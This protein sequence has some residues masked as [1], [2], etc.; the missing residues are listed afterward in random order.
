MQNAINQDSAFIFTRNSLTVLG[1]YPTGGG[2]PRDWKNNRTVL[3]GEIGSANTISDN[4]YHVV[5]VIGTSSLPVDNTLLIDGFT[6]NGGNANDSTVLIT[7]IINSR[8]IYRHRGGGMVNYYASPT[9]SNTSFNYNTASYSGLGGAIYNI[10]ASPKFVKCL[11]QANRAY[12]GAGLYNDSSASPLILSSVISGNNATQDGGGM[13]NTYNDSPSIIYTTITGNTATYGYGGAILNK[14][15]ASPIVKNSIVYANGYGVDY[16]SGIYNLSSGFTTAPGPVF[17]YSLILGSGGSGSSYWQNLGTDAGHNI[18][19]NPNFA[20]PINTT[21]YYFDSI[22]TGGDFQLLYNSGAIDM[23]DTVGLSQ[24]LPVLDLANNQRIWGNVIDMGAYEFTVPHVLYVDSGAITGANNGAD[25]PN[26]F[27]Q[28]SAATYLA[29]LYPNVDTILVAK[30]TYYPTGVQSGSNRDSAFI[31]TRDGLVLLGG[32]PNGG[33]N[34]R[35]SIANATILSGDIGSP[36]AS[37]DN[38]CHVVITAGTSS[39]PLSNTLTL[40]GFTVTAGNANASTGSMTVNSQIISK[41]NG[42]GIIN[43]Y[44]SPTLSNVTVIKHSAIGNGGGIYNFNAS[45]ILVNSAVNSNNATLNGGGIFDTLSSS[46]VITNTAIRG[47]SA[48][49]NG[50]GIFNISASSPK[51]VGAVIS[52]NF[53]GNNGGGI[54]NNTNA[55]PLILNT[56]ITGNFANAFA[57]GVINQSSSAPIIKNTIIYGNNSGIVNVS[58]SATVSNSII[59]AGSPY[60]GTNNNINQNP[61]FL[62]P[63]TASST[64]S[65]NGNFQLQYDSPAIDAGD[66]TG[67]SQYLPAFDGWNNARILGT[68]VDIGAFE[69]GVSKHILYVDS[70]AVAGANNGDS[71]AD[72]LTTLSMATH[73]ARNFTIIDT[74]LVAKGTYYPT[75]IPTAANRDSAFIFTRSNLAV[76][77][78]YPNGG[79]LIRNSKSNVTALSGNIG[80]ASLSSDNSYH[81]VIT[82]G[83]IDTLLTNTL[84]FDGFTLTGGNANAAAGSVIINSQMIGKQNGAGM[85]NYYA[86]PLLSNMII[87]G[88]KAVVADISG[89]IFSSFI[90]KEEIKLGISAWAN[91]IYLIQLPDGNSLKV[92][93]E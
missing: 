43:Y 4:S 15:L 60:V 39:T 16:G 41:K 48:G 33:S 69:F 14:N 70:S 89:R 73:L 92:V 64:P 84:V 87:T 58:S 50:G 65:T 66:T 68:N 62:V 5:A 82:A 20:I 78:G 61:N 44:A 18:D 30:G 74:I 90:L 34:M 9:I 56:T 8:P 45:P 29:Q 2:I 37:G 83:T 32:Y 35:N 79:G 26:A 28:L 59:Q 40:D 7:K 93:K 46:P 72:A 71:W 54:G 80:N 17:S 21:L 53:A 57:G 27:R 86:S 19:I 88:Q 6:I 63:L 77:G 12:S 36:D 47:N 31:F 55:A 91:G 85:S 22:T 67:I 25:W 75:G 1:G 81:V 49:G 13:V 11:I 10:Y 52:G 51:I 23:G 42:A 38:S 76:L 24:Y 3:S